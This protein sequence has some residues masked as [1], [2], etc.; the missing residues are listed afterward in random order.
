MEKSRPLTTWHFWCGL[1]IV[2]WPSA[3]CGWAQSA[4]QRYQLGR[5][6]SRFEKAWQVASPEIRAQCVS[7]MEKAVQS[8]FGLQL[9]Q[10]ARLLDVAWLTASGIPDAER[11][12]WSRWSGLSIDIEASLL[13]TQSQ[14]LRW[15]LHPVYASFPEGDAQPEGD[16]KLEGVNAPQMQKEAPLGRLCLNLIRGDRIVATESWSVPRALSGPSIDEW[17]IWNLPRIDEGD[18][19]VQATMSTESGCDIDLIADAAS[20]VPNLQTRMQSLNEW[21]T[22]NRKGKGDT[23]FMTLRLLARELQQALKGEANEAD[24]P[25]NQCLLDFEQLV[26]PES[27]VR[28][29][30]ERE[31]PRTFWLNLCD[32]KNNQ[33]VRVE[34][35]KLSGEPMPVLCAFH[36]A[37][38]SE[39]M[40]FETYGA[41]RLIDLARQ[42]TWLVVSPRQTMS[43]NGLSMNLEQI[44]DGLSDIAPTASKQAVLVGHSMGAAQAIS[45]ASKHPERVRAVVALGGGGRPTASDSIAQIPFWIAA[46][47]NDFGRSGARALATQLERLGC[48]VAYRDYPEVEHMVIVQ[49]AL[50]DLFAFLDEILSQAASSSAP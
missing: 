26:A 18:Y 5:R 15:R 2:L 32:G 43:L 11:A 23:R 29:W 35:P 39:N 24:Y 49:A 4:D 46:G 34:V 12:E 37:G 40:F 50:D 10:A 33:I 20:F 14:Q 6:L 9:S 22:A 36:G 19:R 44:L 42:R 17:M 28:T 38:G 48:V 1:V 21:S 31:A 41:G 8:F 30:I 7:S 3:E 47:S 45:Q 25:W 27:S 16:T 13:D